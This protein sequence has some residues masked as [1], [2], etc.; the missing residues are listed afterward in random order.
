MKK[1]IKGNIIFLVIMILCIFLTSIGTSYAAILFDSANVNY[2]NTTSGL[3]A[4]K[5]QDAIDE[6]YTVG[7]DYTYIDNRITTFE[8]KY[9]DFGTILSPGAV[10]ETSIRSGK[11]YLD[12]TGASVELTPGTWIV[13]AAG[14]FAANSTG[15]R[16][17]SLQTTVSNNSCSGDI[18]GNPAGVA[19]V[20]AVTSSN[21]TSTGLTTVI[22]V[23]STTTVYLCAAQNSGSALGVTPRMHA[24]KVK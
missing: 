3:T 20:K 23:T 24:F 22:E 5:V 2:D 12:Y 9:S 14:N 15:Y 6:L 17:L 16:L 19:S 21:I 4:T 8:T 18:G 10:S 7:T 1:D 11:G 13:S